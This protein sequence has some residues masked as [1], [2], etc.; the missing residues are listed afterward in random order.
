MLNGRCLGYYEAEAEA[1]VGCA[2]EIGRNAKDQIPHGSGRCLVRAI[3]I[4]SE[5]FKETSVR[6]SRY[7]KG[8]W[9]EFHGAEIELKYLGKVAG[10]VT[11]IHEVCKLENTT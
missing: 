8:Y 2:G 11:S 9:R 3:I 1:E 5:G 4:G 10:V 7:F 6:E